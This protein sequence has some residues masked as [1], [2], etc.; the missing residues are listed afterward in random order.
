MKQINLRELYPDI[1][2]TDIYVEDTDDV[3]E[4]I[5]THERAE[6]ACKRKMYRYKAHYSLDCGDG[7]EHDALYH[8]PTPEEI[9]LEQDMH[10]KLY[11]AIMELPDKQAHRIYA[12]FYLGMTVADIAKA[13]GVDPRRVRDSIK[14]GLDTLKN[15]VKF[16]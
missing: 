8:L 3:W 15:K 12:R 6:T 9:M 14:H 5:N 2:K 4:V 16:F 7:I 13:D 1:Y 10:K 11:A